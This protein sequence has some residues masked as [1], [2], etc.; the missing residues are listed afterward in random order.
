MGRHYNA[1]MRIYPLENPIMP[2][3]WGSVDG[4]AKALG[5]TN[6]GGGPQAELWMGA[7]PKA[8]STLIL[9]EGRRY[10]DAMISSD[11]SR[12]IGDRVAERY[13]NRLPFLFKVLSAGR[14]LSIQ[15][16]PGLRK[17]ERGFERENALGIA[18]DSPDRNYRDPNHKPELSVALT[19]FQALIGFRPAEEITAFG[20][21]LGPGDF[22]RHFESLEKRKGRMELSVFFYALMTLSGNARLNLIRRAVEASERILRGNA[23]GVARDAQGVARDA[24]GVAHGPRDDRETLAW[25]WVSRLSKLWPGDIGVLAPLMFNVVALQPGEAIFIAP[26]EPH[27]YLNGTGLEIMANSDNVIR[28]ALTEKHVDIPEFI[29]VLGFDAGPPERAVVTRHGPGVEGFESGIEDFALYRV[30]VSARPIFE[31]QGPE[32]ILCTEGKAVI[33]S[34]GGALELEKG[35]SA[36]VCASAGQWSAGGAGLLW[37]ATVGDFR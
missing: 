21:E 35:Q 24:Q 22:Q 20:K 31:V 29:S 12:M 37:R 28:C 27:A 30:D 34:A 18:Q 25:T 23:Q 9:P 6:E 17:A 4:I 8:P 15:V 14:P 26:G 32:I 16:H 36:F 2:Y 11:P 33:R 1:A 19:E 3:A 5:L 13:K 7:H 10:L